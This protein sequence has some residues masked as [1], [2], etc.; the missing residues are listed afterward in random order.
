MA[1]TNRKVL[2]LAGSTAESI[3]ALTGDNALQAREILVSTDT[4]QL[5]IGNGDDT[6]TIIGSV[7]SGTSAERGDAT[8]TKGQLFFDT[9]ENKLYIGDGTSWKPVLP[10]TDLSNYIQKVGGATQDNIAIL[11]SDG[12]LKD[13]TYKF[14][15]SG[16]GDKDIWSGKKIA[17]AIVDAINGLVW[18][19][20]VKDIVKDAP[21]EPA[22]V[23]G[24]R[25]LVDATGATGA[26]VGKENNIAEYNGA[27]WDFTPPV[28]GEA[29][30]VQDTDEQWT[31]NGTRWVNIGAA[32]KYTA[33][34]GLQ[35]AGQTFSVKPKAN[36]GINADT[37][38]VFVVVKPDSGI[39]V[40]AEGISV[41][42]KADSGI[43]VSA[44]G[45]AFAPKADAGLTM[46]ATGVAVKVKTDGGLK[47]DSTGVQIN[48]KANGGIK[49]SGEGTEVVTD[50]KSVVLNESGQ[51]AVGSLDF[52]T[53]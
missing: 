37:D 21:A 46:D 33:G 13:S 48:P 43:S 47:V 30:Y 28:E 36:G 45:L 5:F 51:L 19:Q 1:V 32:F 10:E 17:E 12:T 24:D 53:F 39:D 44:D 6:Y 29:I 15:D 23:A 34:N 7:T 40:A 14:N 3:K 26:F 35:L 27:S 50:A 2:Q 52:G 41:K 16:T 18:Q 38:G 49:V 9:D 42:L 11:N 31:Y 4:H 22:P 25:Y 20:P 8:A